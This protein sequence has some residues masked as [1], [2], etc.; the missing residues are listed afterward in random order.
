MRIFKGTPTTFG[1]I[2]DKYLFI[3]NYHYDIFLKRSEYDHLKV[4]MRFYEKSY[5][6]SRDNKSIL[7][8][9]LYGCYLTMM[10][11]YPR[12]TIMGFPKRSK[13]FRGMCKKIGGD[14]GQTYLCNYYFNNAK[15]NKCKDMLKKCIDGGNTDPS[16]SFIKVYISKGEYNRAAI[17]LLDVLNTDNIYDHINALYNLCKLKSLN[18]IKMDIEGSYTWYRLYLIFE[19]V[20]YIYIVGQWRSV[21]IIYANLLHYIAEKLI[22]YCYIPGEELFMCEA[23]ID[24]EK[25]KFVASIRRRIHLRGYNWEND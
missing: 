18:L 22:K 8:T 6:L 5:Y 2:A 24:I 10:K 21:P 19:Q 16:Y 9:K 23:T 11:F 17:L 15:W 20:S 13:R 1:S 3:A 14:A 4:A 25:L 7:E 12:A